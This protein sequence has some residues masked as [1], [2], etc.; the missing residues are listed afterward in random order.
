M[1][2]SQGADRLVIDAGR[3]RRRARVRSV[4]RC[5]SD[6]WAAGHSRWGYVP[7]C[8]IAT[9]F[10]RP[11]L[12]AFS[13]ALRATLRQRRLTHVTIDPGLEGP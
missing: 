8:P 9:S 3:R 10:D 11:S 1:G 13:K 2:G 4:G 12:E 6:R 7:R 5:S